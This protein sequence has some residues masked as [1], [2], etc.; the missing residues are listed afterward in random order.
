MLC[1]CIIDK[2]N[3]DE[4]D[5]FLRCILDS[6][7]NILN[8]STV[9]NNNVMGALLDIVLAHNQKMFIEPELV[10]K[11]CRHSGLMPIGSLILEE[12][13]INSDWT[14]QYKLP[15]KHLNDQEINCWVKLA[16]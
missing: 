6:I 3:I 5:D 1:E 15:R 8:S 10:L 14:P 4:K 13:L 2:I 16:T 7:V 9:Y 11:V 12:Y